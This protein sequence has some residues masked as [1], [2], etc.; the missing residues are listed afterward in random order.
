MKLVFSLDEVSQS[1][2]QFVPSL[3]VIRNV[4]DNILLDVAELGSGAVV[5]IRHALGLCSYLSAVLSKGV[6]SA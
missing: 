2:R 4:N 3:Y 5:S 1:T 6:C